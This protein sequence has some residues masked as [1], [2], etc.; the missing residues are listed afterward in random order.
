MDGRTNELTLLEGVEDRT[1][2][3]CFIVC[4]SFMYSSH[5]GSVAESMY[6]SYNLGSGVRPDLKR[7]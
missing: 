2:S 3:Q 5:V 4:V 7:S 1:C 6:K